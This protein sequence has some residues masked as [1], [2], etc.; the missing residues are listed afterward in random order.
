MKDIQDEKR[1]LEFIHK[2]QED[3]TKTIEV[4]QDSKLKKIYERSMTELAEN[5]IRFY[6]EMNN[7]QLNEVEYYCGTD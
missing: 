3:G 4:W 6:V 7:H 1:L 5:P 2:E